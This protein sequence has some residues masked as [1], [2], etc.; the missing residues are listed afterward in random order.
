VQRGSALFPKQGSKSPWVLRQNYIRDLMM[1]R[2]GAV[3]DGAVVFSKG[4]DPDLPR[5]ALADDP[6]QVRAAA[7]TP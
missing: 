6:V 1:M 3:D 2:F 7:A 4:R 5:S